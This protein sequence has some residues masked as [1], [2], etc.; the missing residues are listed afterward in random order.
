MISEG[1]H[2]HYWNVIYNI[3]IMVFVQD[4][5]QNVIFTKY[6]TNQNYL[7]FK[8]WTLIRVFREIYLHLTVQGTLGKWWYRSLW[9]TPGGLNLHKL[10]YSIWVFENRCHREPHCQCK[11]CRQY[12]QPIGELTTKVRK[13]KEGYKKSRSEILNNSDCRKQMS[14]YL[15]CC[16]SN[17]CRKK[18]VITFLWISIRLGS[19]RCTVVHEGTNGQ[20][21]SL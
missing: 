7:I 21:Q 5:L 11:K 18:N 17:S 20:N 3:Y 14:P 1:A 6:Y 19:S 13:R 4:Y 10:A 15:I 2:N 8:M 12:F 9:G 16:N